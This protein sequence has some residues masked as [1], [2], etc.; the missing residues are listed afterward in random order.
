MSLGRSSLKLAFAGVALSLI[1]GL[2]LAQA[3]I[4][5]GPYD[6]FA[7]STGSRN[8]S[9]GR[10]LVDGTV[11]N[12][13]SVRIPVIVFAVR[14]ERGMVV[15]RGESATFRL[16]PRQASTSQGMLL[17][18]ALKLEQLRNLAPV[19]RLIE[20]VGKYYIPARKGVSASD[21]ARQTGVSL[22][23]LLGDAF[24]GASGGAYGGGDAAGYSPNANMLVIAVVPANPEERTR[25]QSRPLAL[26]Y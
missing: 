15:S 16:D 12:A 6:R 14:I 9:L 5:V 11:M 24:A 19:G 26:V 3:E 1:P 18:Q 22:I 8:S 2:L 4:R 7:S 25:Y 23:R 13:E 21:L 20:T 10:I 17:G